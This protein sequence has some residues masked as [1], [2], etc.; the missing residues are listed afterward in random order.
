MKS[1]PSF[2]QAIGTMVRKYCMAFLSKGSMSGSRQPSASVE[3]DDGISDG[4]TAHENTSLVINSGRQ[5]QELENF[6]T[7]GGHEAKSPN[8]GPINSQIK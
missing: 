6:L 4:T 2:S 7:I 8:P 1:T 3:L 5:D